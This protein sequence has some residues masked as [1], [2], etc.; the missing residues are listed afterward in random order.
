MT[1][2]VKQGCVLAPTLFS[3]MLSA[4]LT[5]AFRESKPGINITFRTDGK[6]FNPRR[7]ESV[8][9]VKE[10]VLRDFLFADDCALNASDEQE[11]QA[12]MDSF[13]AACN[14]FGRTISTK[15]TEVM[16]QPASTMSRRS[17]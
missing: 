17:Q 16:F 6:L 4:M 14:N 1:N 11:M 13:S 7:L 10:T 3:L 9:K 2:G 8:M 5:D 15:K 12:E